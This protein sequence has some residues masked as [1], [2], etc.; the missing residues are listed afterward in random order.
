MVFIQN[1]NFPNLEHNSENLRKSLLVKT[2]EKKVNFN[3]FQ[4]QIG[5][6]FHCDDSEYLT[7]HPVLCSREMFNCLLIFLCYHVCFAINV[8]YN[9]Q[10]LG[11]YYY[12]FI[13]Y[14]SLIVRNHWREVPQ[15]HDKTVESIFEIFTLF[16][17]Q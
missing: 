6:V 1:A 3:N 16:V 2:V 12:S 13:I 9:I 8:C 4:S 11:Y 10:H 14:I 17:L 7:L 5:I 15:S